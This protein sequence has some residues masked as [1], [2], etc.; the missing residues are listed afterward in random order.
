VREH[1]GEE[2]KT[3]FPEAWKQGHRRIYDYLTQAA[4]S[5]PQTFEEMP[6]LFDAMFHGCA[7][8]R[9]SEVR[10]LYDS[11]VLQGYE[12]FSTDRLGVY[13]AGLGALAGFF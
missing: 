10:E 13:G 12:Y 1:V 3:G 5:R 8:G 2:L 7:A 4:P 11:R 9:Y 6:L